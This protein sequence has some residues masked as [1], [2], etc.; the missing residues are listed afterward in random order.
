MTATQAID[1]I[2]AT[3]KYYIGIMSQQKASAII[4]RFQGGRITLRK[5]EEF[6]NAFG[7]VQREDGQW[8]KTKVERPNIKRK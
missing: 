5:L 7:Y 4:I 6:L 3:P 8:I 2:T 1:E